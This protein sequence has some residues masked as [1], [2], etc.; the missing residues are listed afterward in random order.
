MMMRSDA[1]A[2]QRDL[3]KSAQVSDQFNKSALLYEMNVVRCLL[4]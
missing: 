2:V 3:K 1:V 4:Q